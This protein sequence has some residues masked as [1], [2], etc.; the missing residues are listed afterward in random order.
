MPRDWVATFHSGTVQASAH[1]TPPTPLVSIRTQSRIPTEW[2][3]HLNGILSRSTGADHVASYAAP[4]L[5]VGY[6]PEYCSRAVAEQA[7]LL[8][9]SLQRKLPQQ[10]DQLHHF[11]RDGLVGRQCQGCTMIVAGAGRIGLQ[12][13]RLGKA[14]GYHVL[15]IDPIKRHEEL[16]YSSWAE[17]LPRA[18]LLM[19]SM[20]LTEEN[21]GLIAA[22]LL[23]TAPED[24]LIVNVARGELFHLPDLANLLAQDKIGGIAMDVYPEE[25]LFAELLR[26]NTPPPSTSTAHLLNTIIQ[27]P[28]VIATPHNA[29]NTVEALAAKCDETINQLHH[30]KQHQKF[31]PEVALP[32][33]D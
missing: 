22:E 33:K 6:L 26:T 20:N 30:F 21:R 12:I 15:A 32:Q 10:M 9:L 29:F 28:R 18:Q 25:N 5:S 24:L 31:N 2:R 17:A 4:H 1:P 27:D 19:L 8:A 11:N 7:I 16:N 23:A 13:A 14:L 3:P